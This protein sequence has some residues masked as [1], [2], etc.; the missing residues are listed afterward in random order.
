MTTVVP[1]T[2]GL[3]ISPWA[4]TGSGDGIVES[5]GRASLVIGQETESVV[6]STVAED[7]PPMGQWRDG[8]GRA[9]RR[10]ELPATG[11][12]SDSG[13][14]DE[15]LLL[16]CRQRDGARHSSEVLLSEGLPKPGRDEGG[17]GERDPWTRA[18]D[19]VARLLDEHVELAGDLF[20]GESGHDIFA[21]V[22]HAE[23]FALRSQ[24]D[25]LG[26]WQASGSR[27]EPRRALIVRL[28]EDRAFRQLLADVC[29]R[30]RRV[31][32]RRR[33]MQSIG[34]IQEVDPACLRWLVRQPGISL[35]QK[36]GPRQEALGVVRLENADTP[37]NRVVRDLLHRGS[38]AC[39]RYVR[40]NAIF[41]GHTRVQAV[42]GFRRELM[43]FLVRSAI[44]EAGLLVGHATP[45]YV[46]QHD[47][48]YRRIWR[49]YE[50]L[51]RHQK[52]QDEVWRWR[53][54]VWAEHTGLALAACLQGMAG[55]SSPTGDLLIRGE[56]EAGEYLD[57]RSAY[58]SF[59]IG[60]GTAARFVDVVRRRQ[61]DMHSMVPRELRPLCPDLVLVK[62]SP[63]GRSAEDLLCVW[64]VLD[65]EVSEPH[66]AAR[67]DDLATGLSPIAARARVRAV[68]VQPH[69]DDHGQTAEG[70][71]ERPNCRGLRLSAGL[72]RDLPAVQHAL[73]WGLGL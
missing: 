18:A 63:L 46:L 67:L 45:N 28:A 13:P 42:R 53:H 30:P 22:K 62:R 6:A 34:R 61:L 4:A 52:E 41:H 57:P 51:R 36:A 16:A 54:R 8:E 23:G 33:E 38:W 55:A 50:K 71:V 60:E 59:R 29:N 48:R 19:A 43:G 17:D 73:R 56:H 37:E 21:G 11:T 10:F 39:S 14:A 9:W 58:A 12:E 44:A 64:A 15:W 35:A 70:I 49:V 27:G 66:L 5:H 26:K 72:Q 20:D 31:L 3:C 47:L 65:M 40:E 1:N 24:S 68:V 32:A 25:A 2:G 7:L 69:L